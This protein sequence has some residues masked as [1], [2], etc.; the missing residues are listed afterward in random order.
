MRTFLDI[1][2]LGAVLSIGIALGFATGAVG[3]ESRTGAAGQSP[4]GP[5]DEIG[6][7][8]LMTD[9]S[10]LAVLSRVSSGKVYDLSVEYRVGMASW[11][12]LGEPAYQIWNIH[13]PRGT[14]IDNPT[15]ASREAN[16]LVTYS[17]EAISMYVH[18]GTHIDTLNHFGL[19]GRIWN[20]FQADEHLG[21]RGWLK[22]GAETVPPIIARGVLIDVAAAKGMA[23]LPPRYGISAADLEE[24]LKRQGTTLRKGDVVMVRTGRMSVYQDNKAYLTDTP[25]LTRESAKYLADAGAIVVGADNISTDVSPSQEP[26]N[27]IPVHSYLLT[28]R[29]VNTM[30]SVYLEELARDRVYEFAWIGAPLK[31]KG[32]SGAPMRPIALPIR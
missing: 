29:G 20:G 11:T 19:R 13:T 32:A 16:E 8:N 17:G 2:R 22:S 25:G 7:L 3:A 30:Q 12:A 9:A 26:D 18:T 27:W 23:M 21:D 24:A 5:A 15:G 4:F 14:V 10:R 1:S 31:L 28:E 6:M